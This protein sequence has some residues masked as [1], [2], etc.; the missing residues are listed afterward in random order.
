MTA[1]PADS[2][3]S[4]DEIEFSRFARFMSRLR[5]APG[6]RQKRVRRVKGDIAV[7]T[8]ETEEKLDAACAALLADMV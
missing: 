4:G 2:R 7:G 5:Q 6:I 3:R 8:Y 1:P